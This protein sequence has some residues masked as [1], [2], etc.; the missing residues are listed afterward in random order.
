MRIRALLLPAAL[1]VLAAIPARAQDLP[2][3]IRIVVPL[4]AGASA[5]VVSGVRPP[6]SWLIWN[7]RTIPRRTRA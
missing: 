5:S 1:A 6:K 7:V 4:A 3:Q 2:D